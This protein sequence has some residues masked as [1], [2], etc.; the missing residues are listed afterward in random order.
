[1]LWKRCFALGLAVC[2][3]GGAIAQAQNAS[4]VLGTPQYPNAVQTTP[5]VQSPILGTL[6]PL[7]RTAAQEGVDNQPNPPP[8]RA[9]LPGEPSAPV[10]VNEGDTANAPKYGPTPLTEVGII[11][12]ALYG[13]NA[14][15]AWLHIAG[16]LDVDYTFRST[17]P[18]S[19]MSLGVMNRFGDEADARD[20]HLISTGRSTRRRGRGAST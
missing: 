19:T 17:A 10:A 12:K 7:Y 13:D 20:R 3:G 5:Y 11:D 9:D 6:P 4:P 1:M 18:A 2:V 16:W 14:K 15:D 8:G